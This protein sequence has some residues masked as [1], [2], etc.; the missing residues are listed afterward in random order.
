MAQQV[1]K[2]D[3]VR[4][5]ADHDGVTTSW[6]H[7]SWLLGAGSAPIDGAE[8]TFGVVTINPG[9]RNPL[10]MH[11]NCE[12]LLFVISGTCD[13]LLG[14]ETYQMG[15]GS[16]IRIPRG[17]PHWAKCTSEEPLKVVVSFSS[18]DRQTTSLEGG[19]LA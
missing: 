7:L 17:V 16:V 2:Q 4:S 3:V 19:E 18:P 9:Q 6:G 1:A 10:H 8:Q 11:P 5:T 15:P 14:D 12:E 13:H